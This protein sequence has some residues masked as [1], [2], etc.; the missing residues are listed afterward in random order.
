MDI[1]N[2]GVNQGIGMIDSVLYKVRSHRVL[3]AVVSLFLILYAVFAA[4]KLP[5]TI[6]KFF[7]N[8]FFRLAFLFL[9]AYLASNDPMVAVITAIAFMITF[10]TLSNHRAV[11]EGFRE[12]FANMMPTTTN[13]NPKENNLNFMMKPGSAA[14]SEMLP[15]P[16]GNEPSGY[17]DDA[18]TGLFEDAAIPKQ[19]LPTPQPSVPSMEAT[20]QTNGV[21]VEG[22]AQ[23]EMLVAAAGQEGNM[24]VPVSAP[25]EE[26]HTPASTPAPSCAMYNSL[27]NLTGFD[28]DDNLASI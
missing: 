8:M 16:L 21:T 19:E 7:D 20:G 1:V 10:Q 9:I 4:P 3:S 6:L 14:L 28:K 11:A 25:S 18:N 23:D 22:F 27:G 12:K 26:V 15:E 24:L 5:T 2:Q 13:N 17:S